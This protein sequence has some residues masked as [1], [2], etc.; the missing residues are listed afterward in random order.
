MLN[1]V[2]V[3]VI[4]AWAAP[5][6]KA[7]IILSYHLSSFAGPATA[8]IPNDLPLGPEITG[9]NMT[10]GEVLYIQI[11]ITGNA[12]APQIVNGQ[13]QANWGVGNGMSTFVLQFNY[14]QA[15]VS[16]P[17]IAPAPPSL[18]QN[19]RNAR[20]Q[21]PYDTGHPITFTGYNSG[22]TIITGLT[23]G[24]GIEANSGILPTTVI[25]TLKLVATGTGASSFT[26]SD[27][28]PPLTA[29]GFGLLDDT[30]LDAIIFATAH[31]N[32]PFSFQVTAAPEPSSLALAGIAAVF[33]WRRLRRG[34]VA[35]E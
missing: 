15:M 16:Q 5:P 4:V 31:A 14:P 10:V 1:R 8:P 19:W 35:A 26:I 29:G 3:F 13:N 6:A 21:L 33:G 24:A 17:Y 18:A 9:L 27:P 32:F 12:N 22:A 34:Q 23:L 25:A 20:S 30:N 2:I 28:Q 11:A 7:D